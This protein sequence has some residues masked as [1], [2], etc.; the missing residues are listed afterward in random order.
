MRKIIL[1]AVTVAA[2]CAG[3]SACGGDA[4][5]FTP[6]PTPVAVSESQETVPEDIPTLSDDD[7]YLAAARA[8]APELVPVPDKD[9]L[10]LGH[11]VCEALKVGA[12]LAE[13]GVIMIQSG[14]DASPSGAVVGSATRTFCPEY[15]ISE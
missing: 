15:S 9:L 11:S 2:L 14:L 1:T 6:D 4:E 8:V 5:G 7:L 13:V 12:T 3:L 10:G